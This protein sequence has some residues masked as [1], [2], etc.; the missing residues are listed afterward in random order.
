[1][2]DAARSLVCVNRRAP[3][4]SIIAQEA[5]EVVLLGAAFEQR[6]SLLF[7]DDGVYQLKRG[8][9]TA[10]LGVKDFARAFRALDLYDLER[11]ALSRR[12]LEARGLN[13]DDLL[14]AVQLLDDAQIA[15]LLDGADVVLSF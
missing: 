12:C 13:E 1:M 15:A 14:I 6:V 2:A 8:Q 10:S 5:L 4:G 9:D 7:M 3:H 11:I